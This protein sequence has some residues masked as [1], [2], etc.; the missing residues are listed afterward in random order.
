[1]SVLEREMYSE[2]EAA[3]LLGVPQSTLHWWLEGGARR[4]KTYAPVIRARSSGSKLVS[5]GEFVEA[6]LLRQYR[7]EHQVPLHEI[8]IFI[9]VLRTSL[10]VPYP[11]AHARPF[12]GEGRH[13]LLEAQHEAAVPG[14]FSLVAEA[15][16]QL[17][18][19][20][21]AHAYYTRVEWEHDM[22]AQWRPHDDPRSP[23]R[24]D[25]LVRFGRPSIDGI[26]TEVLWEQVED[27][28]GLD[29]LAE[30]FS[31]ASA[32]VRWAWSYENSA[33]AA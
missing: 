32:S 16:G 9:D 12:V 5:W 8:R 3:R 23:V 17:L 15:S 7:R 18:L 11:L 1:M 25:P 20:P 27:G 26:S 33:R 24:M 19:T 6:G 4:S 29:E 10:D 30:E 2:P 28:A 22:A 14:D 31:L 13:L 21:A